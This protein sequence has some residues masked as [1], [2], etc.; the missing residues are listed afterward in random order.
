MDIEKTCKR[1]GCGKKYFEKDNHGSACSFHPGIPLF[2]DLKK[3]YTCC[4]IVYDWDEFEKIPKCAIGMH[5]DV[6]PNQG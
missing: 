5:S 4:K 2:H 1:V 3:G 6:D